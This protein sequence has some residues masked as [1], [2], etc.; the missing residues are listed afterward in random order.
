MATDV[1][2]RPLLPALPRP[3]AAR[4]R[5]LAALPG[6]RTLPAD[7]WL[8]RH[9]AMLG[10]LWLHVALLPVYSGLSGHALP[11]ALG[12]AALP[13][14]FAALATLLRGEARRGPAAAAVALGLLTCSAVVVH[15]ADG[16]IEAHFH[17]FVV[18][19]ALT[20]WLAP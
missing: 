3:A 5:L 16:L 6:G 9:R 2:H 17:F 19:V 1:R 7:E 13:G 18:I 20:L 8:R 4:G 10:L 15:I 12:E 11:H 14:T